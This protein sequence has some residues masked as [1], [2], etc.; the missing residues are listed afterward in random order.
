MVRQ[1]LW[2]FLKPSFPVVQRVL[3]LPFINPHLSKIYAINRE[4]I[5]FLELMDIATLLRFEVEGYRRTGEKLSLLV[6]P[7]LRLRRRACAGNREL[8]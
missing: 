2:L 5:P 3:N 7:D 4:L 1:I 8:I 6:R